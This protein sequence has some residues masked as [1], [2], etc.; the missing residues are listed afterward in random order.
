MARPTTRASPQWKSAGRRV[1]IIT[2]QLLHGWT[3]QGAL[4]AP[5]FFCGHE[6]NPEFASAVAK[7]VPSPLAASRS[8]RYFPFKIFLHRNHA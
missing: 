2:E 3:R 8:F 5:F 6:R 4:A 7:S 1:A